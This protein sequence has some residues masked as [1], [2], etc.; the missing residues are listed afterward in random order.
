MKIRLTKIDI[1]LYSIA[2]G[3]GEDWWF[4]RVKGH[5]PINCG[6]DNLWCFGMFIGRYFNKWRCSIKVT[7]TLALSV[8][9]CSQAS[10]Y[11]HQFPQIY[12]H[13]YPFHNLVINHCINKPPP[14]VKTENQQEMCRS[15]K[16][17]SHISPDML[18]EVVVVISK[19]QT[20]YCMMT[21]LNWNIFRVTGHL[22]GEFTCHR[23]IPLTKASDAEMFCLIC[24]WINGWVKV[25][26]MIR[27]AI[28]PIMTSP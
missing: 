10:L 6:R 3:P 24:A 23:L 25:R 11:H 14:V 20:F 26:L 15:L 22:C 28:Q 12:H 17:Q 4:G 2:L 5:P 7:P 9:N 27:D 1:K 16:S 19:R 18:A 21:S 8:Q 13:R